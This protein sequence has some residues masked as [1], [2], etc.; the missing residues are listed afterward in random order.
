MQ[1]ELYNVKSRKLAVFANVLA[2]SVCFDLRNAFHCYSQTI[3]RSK[4]AKL[5][6]W[7]IFFL[8]A[9]F[10]NCQSDQ[11]EFSDDN[12]LSDGL[13][14]HEFVIEEKIVKTG[15]NKGLKKFNVTLLVPPYEF[16]RKVDKK[17]GSTSVFTCKSCEALGSRS[18]SAG[19]VKT[20]ETEDGKPEYELV[21]VPENHKCIRTTTSHLKGKFIK[22]LYDAV[23]KNP[24]KS[25]GKIYEDVREEFGGKM[26]EDDKITFLMDIPSFKSVNANLY[27]H[28]QNFI[29]K[30]PL[31]FVSVSFR[32]VSFSTLYLIQYFNLQTFRMSLI[33]NICGLN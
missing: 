31:N 10:V 29:P 33:L 5:S 6:F 17:V 12:D 15:V 27:R 16:K 14:E 24:L 2:N 25:V 9:L 30:A 19:A 26:S 8:S 28:R 18:V 3:V 20:S 22:A 7:L 23:A 21:R 1:N 11:E 4:M 13:P 32:I